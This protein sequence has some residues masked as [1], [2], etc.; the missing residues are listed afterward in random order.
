MRVA[1][2]QIA[3]IWDWLLSMRIVC[4]FDLILYVFSKFKLTWI[5]IRHYLGKYGIWYI[6]NL[7]YILFWFNKATHL[8]GIRCMTAHWEHCLELLAKLGN[9]DFVPIEWFSINHES[10][11][12]EFLLV[13]HLMDARKQPLLRQ[14]FLL[15]LLIL[16]CEIGAR[17][18]VQNV[19]ILQIV[20][21]V[22]ATNDV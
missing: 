19:N 14:T 2:G 1:V 11:I 5:E 3:R 21:A 16:F 7:N 10:N 8:A 18:R 15:P 12:R 4:S 9:D 17:V 20:L 6:W 13:Q 22:T